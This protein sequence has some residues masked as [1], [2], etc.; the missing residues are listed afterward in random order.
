V[1]VNGILSRKNAGAFAITNG[2][3]LGFEGVCPRRTIGAWYPSK[4]CS[5]LP[6]PVKIAAHGYTNRYSVVVGREIERTLKAISAKLDV[7]NDD[8]TGGTL[9][10][11]LQ[12]RPL[13]CLSLLGPNLDRQIIC[14]ITTNVCPQTVILTISRLQSASYGYGPETREICERLPHRSTRI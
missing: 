5:A 14:K 10:L 12:A 3:R 2:R 13:L 7:A 9:V 4:V 8:N 1:T 11:C 6:I